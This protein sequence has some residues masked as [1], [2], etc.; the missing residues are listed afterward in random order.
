V[1]VKLVSVVIKP[2]KSEQYMEESCVCWS[3]NSFTYL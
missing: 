2:M 1:V 3:R